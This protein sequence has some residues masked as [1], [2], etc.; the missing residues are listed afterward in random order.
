MARYPL[1]QWPNIDHTLGMEQIESVYSPPW[2][3]PLPV[4]IITPHKSNAVAV[5]EELLA[6]PIFAGAVW[7]TDGSLLNGS[8]GGAAVAE[9]EVE[10]LVQ[11]IKRALSNNR[12]I[13]STTPRAGQFR[14]ILF[15]KLVRA[16][17]ALSLG[18]RITILWTPAHIG[19]F[20]NEHTD[21]AAKAATR[22]PPP[23]SLPVSLTTCKREI[24]VSILKRWNS[25]WKVATTGRGL[26]AI[27]DTP[28][29]LIL[30][31]PYASSAPR[32]AITI[33]SQLRTDFSSLNAH[34]FRCRL[35]PSPASWEHLRPPLQHTSYTAGILSAVDVRTLLSHPK[36]LKPVIEFITQTRRFC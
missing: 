29:S 27:D 26:R 7:Y 19:T 15:D 8:A 28:P 25:Q 12:A 2:A 13:L 17:A 1:V 14:M 21:D 33:L 31:S 11:A 34:R 10:G 22:L 4:S 24:N 23:S 18:L 36:L 32:A 20:G 3:E 16:A 6:D 9:G 30:R 35:A 5:L